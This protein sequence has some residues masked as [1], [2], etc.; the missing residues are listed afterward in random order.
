METRNGGPLHRSSQEWL[1]TLPVFLLLLLVVFLSSGQIIHS[2]LLKIGE[3]TWDEYFLLR[4]AGLVP[5]PTCER[6]PDIDAR[7][8]EIVQR[9][10]AQANDDPLADILGGGAVDRDAVRQSLMAARANCRAKWDRYQT[11]EDQ[12]TPGV[13]TVRNMEGGVATVVATLGD[14]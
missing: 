6:D 7:T 14:Y 3:S 9:R 12:V 8:D 2:Q 11:V 5:P 13:V 10:Q 4:T 1:S